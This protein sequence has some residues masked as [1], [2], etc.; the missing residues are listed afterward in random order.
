[1][2]GPEQ[3]GRSGIVPPIFW[4][5]AA[6]VASG[7]AVYLASG[8]TH[9]P[10]EWSLMLSAFVGGVTLVVQFLIDFDHRLHEVEKG[11]AEHPLKVYEIVRKSF[12][13]INAATEAYST[14][15]ESP[16]GASMKRLVQ[17]AA[18]LTGSSPE[19]ALL[20]ARSEIDRT[21]LFIRELG[22]GRATY[23]GEDQDWLITLTRQARQT[24]DAT[25]TTAVDGGGKNFD[26]GF[27]TTSLGQRYLGEQRD[28][29]SR[30][31]AIRRLFILNPPSL[32][33][34]PGFKKICTM[35][36]EAHIEVRILDSSRIPERRVATLFDF[37][38][39]DNAVSYEAMAATRLDLTVK[40][41]VVATQLTTLQRQRHLEERT[42]LFA[43]LW[44]FGRPPG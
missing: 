12:L 41:I 18:R 35:Q 39:F 16:V 21:A 42:A 44:E 22:E 19:L 14:I 28:A 15:Q 5:V 8:A 25:S 4:K 23:D 10:Q 31:V 26:D 29:V 2:S 27:W 6:P 20:L 38:L 3:P 1:M 24:I 33:K 11:S 30:G 37:I 17:D 40:P 34:D 36:T 32:A 9:Q 13:E 7:G 43:E